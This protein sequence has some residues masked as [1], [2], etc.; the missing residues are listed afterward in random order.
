MSKALVALDQL[1]P[2]IA[3]EHASDKELV[4]DKEPGSDEEPA[5]DENGC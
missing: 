4:S 1:I 5:S 3:E 2:S